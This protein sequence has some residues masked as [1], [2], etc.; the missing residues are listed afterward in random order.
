MGKK[1]KPAIL[2]LTYI[3]FIQPVF[4]QLQDGF[5]D[6][7]VQ[8]F[9]RYV[10]EVP[11]EEIF[12]HS[13]R[14]EYISGEDFWFS[15]YLIDR[16][17]FKPSLI[18][19]IVYFELLNPENMPVVQKRVLVDKGFGP[20]HFV[21]PDTLS[22]GAYTIRAYT[23]WMKNSLPYNCF[24]KE[25]K[26]FNA[27]I[28]NEFKGKVYSDKTSWE[29]G[30]TNPMAGNA[31]VSLRVNNL[32]PE[33]IELLVSADDNFRT[34]NKN[35]LFIIIQT[36]GNINYVHN[37]TMAG[38]TTTTAVPR[39]VL[40]PG[41]NQITIF[42]S[43]G[44]PVSERL[45]YTPADETSPV[46]ISSAD[47]CNLREK[48][49]LK[50]EPGT[51]A[52]DADNLTNLSI[53]VSPRTCDREI[54]GICDYMLFGTEFGS[55]PWNKIKDKKTRKIN[56]DVIDSLLQNV[57]SNWIRWETIVSGELPHFRYRFEKEDHF[58][59]GKL[60]KSDQQAF[61]SAERLLLCIPGKVAG[62]QN[63]TTDSNG[64]FSF[65][66]HIDE[67]LKDLIIMPD[68][69]SKKS[70]F[71][72]ES[73]FS[74]NYPQSGTLID[75]IKKHMPPQI[76]DWSANY[77]V[78]KIYGIA[79]D[80]SL[81]KP[82]F[83]PL[84]PI[85]F[86]GKPDIELIM[87]EYV[88]LPQMEEVFFEI[89]PD[90]SLKMRNSSYEILIT[91][92]VDDDLN[93]FSPCLMI[94]GVI[95][96]DPSLIVNLDPEIVEKIDVIKEKYLAGDY[97]FTGILNVI[98]RSGDFSCVSLPDYMVRLPYRVIDPVS[99]FASFDYSS[100]EM[101]DSPIPDFRNTLYW[102][103]S[104]RPDKE[105]AFRVEFWTSDVESE[106]EIIIQGITPE[107]KLIYQKKTFRVE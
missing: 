94:D 57:K 73:S 12:I 107:G 43:Q 24:I 64:N 49:T 46:T 35:L 26:I 80:G 88:K 38:A 68:D 45:I 96:K 93:V 4:S 103:P 21:L 2:L 85:R 32:N 63:T 62:F 70:K 11:R 98:T 84:K 67:G 34:E 77:Q 55:I 16:Q 17:S 54:T 10:G 66:L 27:L 95:I 23:N 3:L 15:V 81:L 104:L 42:N 90:V 29:T 101:K 69:I 87:A 7:L 71:S 58:L 22:T 99:S 86:Y 72:I 25:I 41:V 60:F 53:S 6:S 8:R 100:P 28:N 5:P 52:S 30:Q 9:L 76:P 75:S 47:S 79:S 61:T 82:V 56:P 48:F 37:G 83:P 59:T 39:K 92:R 14:E 97:F 18:S 44:K 19:R 50:F 33:F 1:T 40:I 36:R 102:N 20:G 13:D 106:Y 78:R 51:E 65:N 89:L 105:G 91:E 74:E 31:G